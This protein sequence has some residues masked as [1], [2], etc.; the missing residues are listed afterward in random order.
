MV[1][2]P[3]VTVTELAIEAVGVGLGTPPPWVTAVRSAL[4]PADLALLGRSFGPGTPAF[5]PDAVLP[6]SAGYS[7]GFDDE[8]ERVLDE[9]V[10]GLE[11]EIHTAGLAGEPPWSLV[12]KDPRRWAKAYLG[13]LRRAW[14]A[15]EPLWHRAG[16]LLEREVERVGAALA[17]GALPHLLD[18]LTH[19]G[20][21]AGDRWYLLPGAAPAVLL[22][23]MVLQPMLVGPRARLVAGDGGVGYVAYPLPGIGRIDPTGLGESS[24]RPRETQLGALLGEPRAD[25]LRRLDRP[26]PAGRLAVD[27]HFTPSAITHHV[28]ALTR[29]GLVSRERE[30]RQVL[31]SRSAR[32]SALLQIYEP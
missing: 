28:N 23:G 29:A 16:P 9:T 7:A 17:S 14:R 13:A 27:L 6:V 21:V 2:A 12:A 8:T 31:V 24:G 19:R 10:D 15:V 3:L 22:P 25:I 4:D 11:A 32:G 30:G 20:H 5:V 26:T 18:G 1:S